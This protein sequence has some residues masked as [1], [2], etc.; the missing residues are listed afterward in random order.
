MCL[1]MDNGSTG[2]PSLTVHKLT[3]P[4]GTAMSPTLQMKTSR[5]EVKPFANTH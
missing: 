3:Q 1:M 4:G 2:D 5:H